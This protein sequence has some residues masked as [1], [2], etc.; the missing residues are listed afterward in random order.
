M[1]PIWRGDV[2]DE[3]YLRVVRG[4]PTPEELAALI[5][6]LSAR[7]SS[8]AQ[9]EADASAWLDGSRTMRKPSAP[10]SNPAAWRVSGWA[11]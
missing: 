3:L 4:N 9:A 8:A 1:V 10:S 11:G 7:A 5:A 6:V 2:A